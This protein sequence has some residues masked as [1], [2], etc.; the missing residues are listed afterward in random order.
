VSGIIS[1]S[2]HIFPSPLRFDFY[3]EA[4]TIEKDFVKFMM[5]SPFFIFDKAKQHLRTHIGAE[6]LMKNIFN[7]FR[8]WRTGKHPEPEDFADEKPLSILNDAVLKAMLTSDTE[9]SRE[10]LRLLLCACTGREITGVRVLKNELLPDYMDAKSVR[11]DVNVTFNDGDAADLE[12]QLSNSY[13]D[14][15]NRAVYYSAKLMSGQLRKKCQR[16]NNSIDFNTALS[17]TSFPIIYR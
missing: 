3:L 16:L 4:L 13:D 2:W 11:L 14:I 12:M 7:S 8:F 15:K 5:L 6:V 10:A 17:S 1:V 9:D